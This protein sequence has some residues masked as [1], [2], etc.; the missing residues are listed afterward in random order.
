MVEIKR[1]KGETFEAFLRRFNKRLMQS[2][3]VLQFKKVRF[4][5]RSLSRN[6]QKKVKLFQIDANQKRE[7]LK[8]I[9]R[10]PEE[11]Y[12]SRKRR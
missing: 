6:L 12:R 2:G 10:L 8:K 3:K 9:G 11:D 5:N 7:Y 1:K 4:Q